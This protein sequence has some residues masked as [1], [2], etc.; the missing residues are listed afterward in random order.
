MGVYNSKSDGIYH[1]LDPNSY[2]RSKERFVRELGFME[3]LYESSIRFALGYAE[4]K[5]FDK[6][7]E[8][9]FFQSYAELL[10]QKIIFDK[11]DL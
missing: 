10:N 7:G 5:N 2:Y 4:V 3:Y 11:W 6:K 8:A 1:Y 9:T